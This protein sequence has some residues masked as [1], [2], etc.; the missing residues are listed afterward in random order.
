MM[1]ENIS[2][3]FAREVLGEK[4]GRSVSQIMAHKTG[5]SVAGVHLLIMGL[6]T[7]AYLSNKR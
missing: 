4:N 6:V 2:Q 7:M 5:M 3:W 1:T